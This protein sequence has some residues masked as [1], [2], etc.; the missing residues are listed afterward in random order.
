M[1]T[2]DGAVNEFLVKYLQM[3]YSRRRLLGGAVM[4]TL[5]SNHA[6]GEG[7]RLQMRISP[8]R[9]DIIERAAVLTGRTMTEFVLDSAER[10]AARAIEDVQILR[11]T[12]QDSDFFVG[13]FLNPPKAGRNLLKAAE[14]YRR[15]VKAD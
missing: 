5:T 7:S 9:R 6:A 15:F 12:R 4:K 2:A 14:R 13:A 8:K 3:E 10:A 1:E 11:L